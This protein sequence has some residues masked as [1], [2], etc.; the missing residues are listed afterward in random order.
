M[1]ARIRVMEEQAE[2]TYVDSG[3]L[4]AQYAYLGE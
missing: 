1:N 4:A 2:R 3:F